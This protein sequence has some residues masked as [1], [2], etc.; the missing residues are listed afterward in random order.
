MAECAA[1]KGRM[2]FSAPQ[3]SGSELALVATQHLVKLGLPEMQENLA[4]S[5][6]DDLG[7]TKPRAG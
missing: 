4:L 7:V 1:G 2:L 6:D 5:S 3:T